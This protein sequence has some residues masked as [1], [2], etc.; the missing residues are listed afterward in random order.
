[1]QIKFQI[2]PTVCA[3]AEMDFIDKPENLNVNV[4][5]Q[6][7]DVLHALIETFALLAET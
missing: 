2:Q 4:V 5:H 7:Q 3:L 6:E 1:M